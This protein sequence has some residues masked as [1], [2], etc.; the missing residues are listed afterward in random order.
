MPIIYSQTVTR[1]RAT[2]IRDADGTLTP[3]RDWSTATATAITSVSV[4]PKMTSEQRDG[5]GVT[6]TDEWVLY[7][8]RGVKIDLVN[9]DRVLWDGRTLDVIGAPQSWPALFGSGGWHHS[10]ITLKQS[11]F[12]RLDAT[13]VEATTRDAELLATN[14]QHT[15]TP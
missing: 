12:T 4:Q 7:G 10:E 6:V 15:Y 13:G 5:A 2:Q 14:T 8:R 11:P 1:L 3:Q 9:G